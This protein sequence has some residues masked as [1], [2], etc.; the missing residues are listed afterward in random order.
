MKTMKCSELGGVC[1]ELIA[2]ETWDETV[3]EMTAHVMDNHPDVAEKMEKMHKK[4]PKAWSKKYKPKWES[5]P[6]TAEP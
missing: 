3:E 4:N 5:V 2:G 1:D 6:E